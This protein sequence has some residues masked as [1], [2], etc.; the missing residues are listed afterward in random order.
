LGLLDTLRFVFIP[1]DESF[2]NA[3]ADHK[4]WQF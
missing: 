4:N 3:K 2:K 1:S